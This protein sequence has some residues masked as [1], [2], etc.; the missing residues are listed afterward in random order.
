MLSVVLKLDPSFEDFLT[1]YCM[2]RVY[3][4]D[5]V[6]KSVDACSKYCVVRRDAHTV[7]DLDKAGIYLSSLTVTI[8]EL[9]QQQLTLVGLYPKIQTNL[10]SRIIHHV[11]P[12]TKEW[13]YFYFYRT[14]YPEH[15]TLFDLKSI[16]RHNN[17]YH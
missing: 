17:A 12:D 16:G 4:R 2:H 13:V 9:A 3:I 5:I 11:T 1:N 14:S 7:F 15:D 6:E 10:R 8:N